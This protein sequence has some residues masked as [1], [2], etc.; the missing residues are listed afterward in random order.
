MSKHCLH[1]NCYI[2]ESYKR[3]TNLSRFYDL[4]SR[5]KP[6]G[7]IVS[8]DENQSASGDF[9]LDEGETLIDFND[10]DDNQYFYARYKFENQVSN[11]TNILYFVNN[12]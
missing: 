9:Y 10:A 2:A 7:V 11:P 8:L 5:S 6:L 4:K 12:N 3:N 1:V